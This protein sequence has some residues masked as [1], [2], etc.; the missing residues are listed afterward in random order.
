MFV[1]RGQACSLGIHQAWAGHDA[2]GEGEGRERDRERR[3]E[4]RERNN[5]R[6]DGVVNLV[7]SASANIRLKK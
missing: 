4:G 3:E 2:W 7:L 5:D 1:F 6:L